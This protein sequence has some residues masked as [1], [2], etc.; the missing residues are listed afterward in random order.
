[1]N[2]GLKILTVDDEPLARRRISSM[3]KGDERVGSF[4]EAANGDEA[5]EIVRGFSPDIIFLDIQMPGASGF[6]FLEKLHD[7]LPDKMP[8][9]VFVTAYDK[10]ALK[11][12]EVNATDYLLKPFDR[13]RFEKSFSL[14]VSRVRDSAQFGQREDIIRLLESVTKSPE[15]LEWVS[16]TKNDKMSL[17]RIDEVRWIE[18]QGNYVSL[19]L[20]ALN[21]LM[22]EKMDVL[23]RRLD[24]KKFVRIHRSSIINV[25]YIREIQLW[26]RGEQKILMPNGKIFSVSRTYRTDFEKFMKTK[27][28]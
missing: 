24:P 19:N 4:F 12:F 20:G 27:V 7:E 25:D 13:Q 17:F 1:M 5:M 10:Y 2:T 21:H 6:Q 26:G 8:V 3:L 11:A 16:V 14:A 9:V 23:Q 18:A 28:L 15:Y 22:R